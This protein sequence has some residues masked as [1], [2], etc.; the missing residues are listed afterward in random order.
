MALFQ[1]LNDQGKTII[2]VT[3]EAEIAQH[4]RR[5]IRFRD[6]RIEKDEVVDDQVNAIDA[7]AALG[8]APR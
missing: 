3:H 4:C 5:V 2:I 1:E 7:L 6:G 8:P